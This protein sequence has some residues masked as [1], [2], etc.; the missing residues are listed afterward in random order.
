M[1]RR[2]NI[3]ISFLIVFLSI[4]TIIIQFAT[5]YFIASVY[6]IIGISCFV[7]IIFCHIL[8][9]RSLT[10]EACFI[11]TILNVFISLV[12]TILTYLGKDNTFTLVPYTSAL[13]GIV[14]INW[15]V[16]TIHCFLRYL[17]DY[18][19]RIDDYLDYYR[20]NSIVFL[21]FYIGVILYGSFFASAFPWAYLSN[22]DAI[23]FSP[24]MVVSTQIEDYLNKLVPLSSIF[25]YLSSRILTFAPYGYYCT[26]FT[27]KQSRLLRFITL[28]FFP[29]MLEI[30]Q[31]FIY[32]ARCD[33]DDVIYA[34]LGGILGSLLF[35]LINTIYR[36]ITGKDFLAKDP[37]YRFSSSSLHF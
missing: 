30:L 32:P 8:L 9:E 19:T 24:F 7:L 1:Q 31:Y 35:Y 2:T 37:V 13:I 28:L 15:L 36:T 23:N 22:T 10:Y 12:I 6:A 16:P 29:I 4:L 20:N 3:N 27:R 26:L 14:V 34:F 18:G 33:I 25:V 11:Y 17:F 21:M 5:Y